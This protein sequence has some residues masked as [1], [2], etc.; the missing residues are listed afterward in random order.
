MS[1]EPQKLF[2]IYHG[3]KPVGESGYNSLAG[4][5]RALK[6][7]PD[8]SEV[9]QV[10]GERKVTKIFSKQDCQDALRDPKISSK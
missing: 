9:V 3:G 7:F 6:D 8:G 5:C 1:Q 2:E 10:D 4:A